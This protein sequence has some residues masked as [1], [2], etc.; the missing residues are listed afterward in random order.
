MARSQALASIRH[1]L[2][3]KA[4]REQHGTSDSILAT[5]VHATADSTCWSCHRNKRRTNSQQQNVSAKVPLSGLTH[6]S[7][8]FRNVPAS[9]RF[10]YVRS[11]ECCEHVHPSAAAAAAASRSVPRMYASSCAQPPMANCNA[12]AA[13]R[14]AHSPASATSVTCPGP[15]KPYVL[16]T[17]PQ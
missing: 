3:F 5:Q 11:S 13:C 16:L 15:R 10:L 14:G 4:L 1:A 12:S 9:N 7:V 17:G 8:K 2:K 6:G